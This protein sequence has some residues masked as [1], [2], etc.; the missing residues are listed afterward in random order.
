MTRRWRSLAPLLVLCAL[1]GLC[2]ALAW[3]QGQLIPG[4]RTLAGTLNAGVSTGTSSAYILTLNPALPSYVNDQLFTFRAHIANTG[5]A[6]LAVNLLAAKP[7]KKWQGAALVDLAVNDLSAGKEVLILYDGAVMQVLTIGH[8]LSTDPGF[9]VSTSVPLAG[10]T[11]QAGKLQVLPDG[12]LQYTDGSPTVQVRQ[13]F[14]ANPFG[15]PGTLQISSGPGIDFGGYLGTNCPDPSA[16]M[17]GLTTTG[18]AQCA[19]P[20]LLNA[21]AAKVV[22]TQPHTFFPQGVNL[23]SLGAGILT[24]TTTGGNAT[25]GTVAAPLSAIVGV[26]DVQTLTRKRIQPRVI[27]VSDPGVGVPLVLDVGT[28]DLAQIGDMASA[29]TIAN[30]IGTIA[31]GQLVRLQIRTSAPTPILWGPLWTGLTLPTSTTGGTTYDKFWF[32]YNGAAGTLDLI[33][34]SQRVPLDL[35]TGVTAGHYTCPASLDV[36]AHGQLTA[37]TGGTCG[38]GG[39]GGGSPVAGTDRDVQFNVAGSLAADSGN[40]IYERA[41]HTLALQN[42]NFSPASSIQTWR[43]GAGYTATIMLPAL[44]GNIALFLPTTSGFLCTYGNCGG[45]VGGGGNVSNSGTPTAGQLAEWTDATHIQG[46]ATTGTGSPVRSASPAL[47]TPNLG[48]PSTLVL[49]NA[50][51]TPSSIGL[52]NGTGSP[53]STGVTGNLSVNNLNGGSG[54]SSTTFWRGDGTWQPAGAPGNGAA[55]GTTKGIATF[56]AADFND[57]GAGVISLDYT[58]AQAASTSLKGFLTA[59]AYTSFNK[60]Y[61]QLPIVGAKFP[62]SNPGRL[63]SSLTIWRMLFDKNTTQCVSWP[64]IRM[65]PDY[66]NTPVFKAQYS[67]T[68]STSGGV[69]IGVYVRAQAAPSGTIVINSKT[70]DAINSCTDAT[71]P[72]TLGASREISCPLTNNQSMTAGAFVDVKLCRD[73]ANGANTATGDMEVLNSMIEYNK[74]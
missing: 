73:T 54:A 35:P 18:T 1:L 63:D 16:V 46:V 58:N 13:G 50:T 31:A 11:G 38:T 4:N 41:A 49:T 24:T 45:S 7:L 42:L 19:A 8:A 70:Y 34:N 17:I 60:G 32:E 12:R 20:S 61:I 28:F 21:V 23:A 33:L 27:P 66:A 65:N 29:L 43:D 74:N 64:N 2:P 36:N 56:V 44:S 30:P 25:L 14:L 15:P 57:N 37:I 5:A 52:A 72:T 47:T 62:T 39:G 68:S 71:V 22:L 6:T 59:A 9:L 53:L 55:D 51:G 69:A 10:G 48:T 67:M 40:F 3:G 26:D